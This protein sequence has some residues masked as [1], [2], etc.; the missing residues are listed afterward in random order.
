MSGVS[1]RFGTLCHLN[2][3]NSIGTYWG[4]LLGFAGLAAIFQSVTLG[5]CIR[6]Y[7]RSLIDPGSTSITSSNV[8]SS[9]LPS[10]KEVSK[11]YQQRPRTGGFEK[12]LRY[13]GVE[14][15]SS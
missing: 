4:P 15:W 2:H 3:D 13:N 7:L 9:A 10:F 8:A 12:S 5:F 6:V 11:Q 1:Y 14:P